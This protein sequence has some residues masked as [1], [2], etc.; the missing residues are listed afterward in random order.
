MTTHWC[1]THIIT[2]RIR[3]FVLPVNIDD[4]G[5]NE[6]VNRTR[7][8]ACM[9]SSGIIPEC[10]PSHLY[11][12]LTVLRYK[13]L[14]AEQALHIREH[15]RARRQVCLWHVGRRQEANHVFIT[16]GLHTLKKVYVI[17]I[18][19]RIG[20]QWECLRYQSLWTPLLPYWRISSYFRHRIV[21]P[22]SHSNYDDRL[23]FKAQSPALNSVVLA[24][25]C[26]LIQ[27]V[28]L[29][30]TFSPLDIII[31]PITGLTQRRH[32]KM[33]VEP[34]Q[35]VYD[36][37]MQYKSLFYRRQELKPITWFITQH[38]APYRRAPFGLVGS[39]HKSGRPALSA[40][41]KLYS[42]GAL[43]L[44]PRG[45][46]PTTQCMLECSSRE[47]TIFLNATTAQHNFPCS[48]QRL[49]SSMDSE[50]PGFSPTQSPSSAIG[51][52]YRESSLSLLI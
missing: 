7:V 41:P 21:P 37:S 17:I 48:L 51:W 18:P 10:S 3:C 45:V 6:A 11:M 13:Y 46:A 27:S 39:D 26:F 4:R 20:W 5:S 32:V 47:S 2:R 30:H 52:T 19:S 12:Y 38:S 34:S 8:W 40:S 44:L 36:R 14:L 42:H 29:S 25:S 43:K 50:R 28:I 16:S 1:G 15:Y 35:C 31:I 24:Y 33:T 22:N 23:S 9:E 49:S